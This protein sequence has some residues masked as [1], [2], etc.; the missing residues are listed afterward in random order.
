MQC[1]QC[2]VDVATTAKFCRNCGKLVERAV[3]GNVRNICPSCRIINSAGAKFCRN[4]GTPLETQ[5]AAFTEVSVPSIV[6]PNCG[7]ELKKEPKRKTV[8]GNCKK[9][10]YVKSRPTDRKKVIVTQEQAEDIEHEWAVTRELGTL[11]DVD[12]KRFEKIRTAQKEKYGKEIP[13][14][15]HGALHNIRYQS[16]QRQGVEY[17]KEGHFGLFRNTR[18]ELA[19]LLDEEGKTDEQKL[20]EAL[21]IYLELCYIDLNGPRNSTKLGRELDKNYQNFEPQEGDLAIGI[22]APANHI[23]ARLAVTKNEVKTLFQEHNS[24]HL[25]GLNLPLSIDDAWK[26]LEPDLVFEH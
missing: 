22:V 13:Q 5:G 14:Q 20:K 9:P 24:R 25:S 18:H 21:A 2:G 6:C 10:I 4:C 1:I 8:C 16:Y 12:R 3:G 26:E 11:P 17:I 15:L 7:V 23:I 19:L